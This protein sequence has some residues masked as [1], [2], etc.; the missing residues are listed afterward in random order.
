MR[1][2][3][4]NYIIVTMPMMVSAVII[5]GTNAMPT[6]RISIVL[7]V[8]D[9]CGIYIYIYIYIYVCVCSNYVTSEYDGMNS[10]IALHEVN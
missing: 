3:E 10:K 5:R 7:R 4:F 6:S 1:D 2:G 8:C 9:V